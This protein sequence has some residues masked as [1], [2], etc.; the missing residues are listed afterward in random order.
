MSV[1]PSLFF[2]VLTTLSL[3]APGV[4]HPTTDDHLESKV[5][6]CSTISGGI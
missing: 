4:C 1:K 2:S 6:A 3:N 5:D